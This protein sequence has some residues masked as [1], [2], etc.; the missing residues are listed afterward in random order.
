MQ[1]E[2][3]NLLK[4][5]IALIIVLL[6]FS[7]IRA[8]FYFSNQSV[9]S[10]N[11]HLFPAFIYGLVYDIRFVLWI[12]SPVLFLFF[13]PFRIRNTVFWQGIV[14]ILFLLI[15]FSVLLFYLLSA[16]FYSVLSP[17]FLMLSESDD[18]I[19]SLLLS[20]SKL[21]FG[22]LNVWDV[23]LF[24]AFAFIVL[25]QIFPSINIMLFERT[26]SNKLTRYA[27][28]ILTIIIFLLGIYEHKYKP[29]NWQTSLYR[30]ENQPSALLSINNSYKLMH[31]Y[32]FPPEEIPLNINSTQIENLFSADKVYTSTHKNTKNVILLNIHSDKQ[33]VEEFMNALKASGF[34]IHQSRNFY[35][36]H[37]T[38][39]S[40]ADELL[41]SLPAFTNKPVYQSKFVFNR[42]RS[43]ADILRENNYQTIWVGNQDIDKRIQAKKNFYGFDVLIAQ[44]G[45]DN[46][47]SELN[48]KINELNRN[49]FIFIDLKDEFQGIGDFL[50][51]AYFN[52]NSF[53]IINLI[54]A[55]KQ[56][57]VFGKT[58]FLLPGKNTE[59]V[60]QRDTLTDVDIFPSL[61]DYLGINTK[62]TAFGESIFKKQGEELFQY[63][64][65]DYLLLNDSLLLR[66]NG[67]S[68]KWLINYKKD[69][70]EYYDLQDNYPVQ[71]IR[72]ENKIRAIL[73]EYKNKLY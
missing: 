44:T 59:P 66:Y 41:L 61:I 43:I 70:D 42:F 58:L 14:K 20:L 71:K 45:F 67:V 27:L 37:K 72:M 2:F 25:W 11:L 28:S 55:V 17:D 33:S 49:Y 69:P 53:I 22:F 30:Y 12:N 51:N 5:L 13:F 36:T 24:S 57:F 7:V 60:F 63:T 4:V 9:F 34:N 31:L 65:N 23:L 46:L 10:G 54:P 18:F 8:Y 26:K 29:G 1:K 3:K 35:A 16:K 40:Q 39:I 62:F 48:K 47:L 32:F 15:N 64:G 73:Q 56:D 38:D 6:F 68:T 19:L 50:S 21:R 52:K